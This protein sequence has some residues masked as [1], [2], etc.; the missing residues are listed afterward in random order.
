MFDLDY[1]SKAP[2]LVGQ[3]PLVLA[4]ESDLDG[5]CT[6]SNLLGLSPSW[7]HESG[8]IIIF[9]QPELRPYWDDFPY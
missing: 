7:N 5:A 9:H 8:Q 1:D 4:P 2:L 3:P 6:Q